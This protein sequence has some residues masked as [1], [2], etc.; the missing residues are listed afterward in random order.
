MNY[1]KYFFYGLIQGFTEF[2]PI[3][4]T[5]HL[6]IFSL[7]F[8][9]EDPGSNLSAIIQFGSLLA[10]LFFFY[11][12][13]NVSKLF[14]HSNCNNFSFQKIL[15]SIS[16][17]TISIILLGSFI[18]LF[19]PNFTNSFFRSNFSI[20]LISILMAMLMLIADHS[21]RNLTTLSNHN[22]IDSF[23]IGLGQAFAI[24]PG[25]SRSGITISVALLMGWRRED[26]A[27]YSYLLGIP[28]IAISS[29][30]AFLDFSKDN[31]LI[32][33]GPLSLGLFTAFITSLLSL[34][35][36]IRYISLKGIKIFAYYRLIFGSFI[37]ITYL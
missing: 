27:R 13:I 18:K 14:K 25:V 34:H 36:L 16:V 23:L 12:D 1:L 10:I 21:K 17:G 35:F 28:A 19:V 8:G 31:T 7:F 5:A 24:I 29:I 9:I 3:S 33:L 6:K 4:S 2:L 32:L 11:K 26:A 22:L 20:G 15:I 37:L 30:A